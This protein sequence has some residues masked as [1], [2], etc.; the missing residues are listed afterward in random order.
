MLNGSQDLFE[1]FKPDQLKGQEGLL[2]PASSFIGIQVC[3]LAFK[4]D[5]PAVCQLGKVESLR[6]LGGRKQPFL[7]LS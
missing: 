1:L 7:T 4:F 5:G 3:L 2:A 6:N